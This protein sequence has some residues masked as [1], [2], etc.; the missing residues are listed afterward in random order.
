MKKKYLIRTVTVALLLM[1]SNLTATATESAFSMPDALDAGFVE[2]AME[3]GPRTWWHWINERVSKDGI[4]KD[5]EAMKTM[6]YKGAHMVNLPSIQPSPEPSGMISSAAR[7]GMRRSALPPGSANG[8]EWSSVSAAARA[9]SPAGPWVAPAQSMQ[10]I[11]WRHKF[12][13]GPTKSPIQL[14]QPN[15][16][17]GFYRDVA[18]VAYPSLPGEAQPLSSLVKRVSSDDF[19]ELDWSAAMD[20]D[21]E[22]Y[23][24]LPGATRGGGSRSVVFEFAEPQTVR[25]LDVELHEDSASRTFKLYG[26]ND[27]K[28]WRYLANLRRWIKHF[29]PRREALAQGFP[30]ATVRFV[31]LEFPA[32]TPD[33]TVPMKLYELNFTSARLNDIFTKSARMR[34]H[35]TISDPST[36]NVPADQ[37][38]AVDQILDLSAYLQPD[39]TLELRATRREVDD[40]AI[41]SYDQ[42]Q[43]DSSGLRACGRPGGG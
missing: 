23:V 7:S 4:T 1:L 42:R 35:P 21:G 30:D 39:G 31:K 5:L 13:T 43:L 22:S 29:D 32:A 9:G 3:Y 34:T 27:G 12:V 15:K 16:T 11:F 24:E 20:G 36:Q 26:S 37:L 19:P 14:P 10:D 25:S 40:P 8:S 18:V 33:P 28:D 17:R 6:G 41:W 2:P 38:I